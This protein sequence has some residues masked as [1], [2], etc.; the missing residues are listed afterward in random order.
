[1]EH[2]TIRPRQVGDALV[3]T[4]PD[5]VGAV[6]PPLLVKT[7]VVALV[8]DVKLVVLDLRAVGLVSVHV[9]RALIAFAGG[10]AGRGVTCVLVPNEANAAV[11]LVLDIVDPNATVARFDTLDQALGGRTVADPEA[12]RPAGGPVNSLSF[13]GTDLD[14]VEAF[15]S[16]A[17]APMRISGA[18][19][20]V[21]FTRLAAGS[22]SV[23][24]LD[25]GFDMVFEAGPIG[26]ICLVDVGSG[27][28]GD[29]LVRGQ[30]APRTFGP[31]DLFSFAPPD[32]PVTGRADHLR[33][34]VTLLA[35]DLLAQV[36]GPDRGIGLLG[37]RPV[38]AGAA[39]RLRS[40]IAH[41]RDNVLTAPETDLLLVSTASQYLAASV[42]QAFPN[43]AVS[44]P[45]AMDDHD[46]HFQT[47]RR[48]MAFIESNAHK[49]ITAT[50][51]ATAASVTSRAVQLS[52]RRH[53]G[54]TPMVYLRRVRLDGAR[55][56]LRASDPGAVTVTR[57]GTRWGFGR[58]STFAALYREAYGEPPSQTLRADGSP[59]RIS[60]GPDFVSAGVRPPAGTGPLDG[61]PSAAGPG[62]RGITETEN[63][64][65]GAGE[66][67]VD[68]F[69][70]LTRRLLH[71]S[72]VAEALQQV[73]DAAGVVVAGADMVSVT[74]R[75]PDGTFHTP[76]Q[77]DDVAAELDQ[78]Q[79]RSGRGP[80]VDA[81]RSDGPGWV[82]SDDLRS[83]TRWPDFAAAT[84]GHGFHAI[85]SSELLPAAGPDQLSGALNF[86]SRRA[87][88]LDHADRNAALLLATHGSLALAH[89]RAAELA[90]LRRAQF[91]RAVDSRDV[92]GQAKGILMNRQGISAD[93][94]FDLLRRTSQQLNVKLLDLA[95]TLTARHSELDER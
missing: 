9:A 35:P 50:D 16:T 41:V 91:E 67:D 5:S 85:L 69:E 26:R 74:V 1:V 25:I 34:R 22:I 3:L 23:D 32:L 65:D 29:H 13:S 61:E 83:E 79:Y 4:L 57:I 20:P 7:L 56:E 46:A 62:R 36:A 52:F 78:V 63:Q 55:A 75:A 95:T 76:V 89:A 60:G 38:D 88:G 51:I 73:A 11:H 92:I 80:C 12:P 48:A 37:H 18:T 45:S 81:A 2:V 70:E 6:S 39:R 31:G 77:T 21:R 64:E 58:A 15:L 14:R 53:L 40:A 59:L 71:T 42:L 8:P 30:R 54:M 24:E 86:Y 43:T 93:E 47:L 44:S 90:D 82:G 94:A 28:V 87:N 68:H 33:A 49:D 84:R 27:T 10:C 72:T 66:V 19:G 17:Y